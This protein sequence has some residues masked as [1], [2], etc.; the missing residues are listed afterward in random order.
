MAQI[1]N[2]ES[3][4]PKYGHALSRVL[5]SLTVIGEP[6]ANITTK[7]LFAW[8]HQ[9]IWDITKASVDA[10]HDLLCGNAESSSDNPLQW[11]HG[12][13][14]Y[15][16]DI[17]R[18]E[19]SAPQAV[20]L[21]QSFQIKHELVRIRLMDRAWL[22]RAY[23]KPDDGQGLAASNIREACK[24]ALLFALLSMRLHV[25]SIYLRSTSLSQGLQLRRARTLQQPIQQHIDAGDTPSDHNQLL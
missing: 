22:L 3:P 14:R 1:F 4:E 18:G 7:T 17:H 6:I 16:I 11:S 12:D 20:L 9:P 5:K 25:P 24:L 13:F 19:Y 10:Q 8:N 21:N 2:G 15:A 23:G